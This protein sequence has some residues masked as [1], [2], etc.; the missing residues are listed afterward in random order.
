MFEALFRM[1]VKMTCDFH[2]SPSRGIGPLPMQLVV[3]IA[4][5][6]AVMGAPSQLPPSRV[7]TLSPLWSQSHI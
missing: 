5:S 1:S 3:V 4:V 7:G 2:M 6:A